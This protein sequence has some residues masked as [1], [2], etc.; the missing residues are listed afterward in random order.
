LRFF[1]LLLLLRGQGVMSESSTTLR[2]SR[3]AMQLLRK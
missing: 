3:L 1:C 2:F